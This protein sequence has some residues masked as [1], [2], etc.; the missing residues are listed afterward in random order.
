MRKT[1][2]L[3]G[4]FMLFCL[5]VSF[6]SAEEK[7]TVVEDGKPACAVVIGQQATNLEKHAAEEFVKYIFQM[8][9]P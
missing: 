7:L 5:S 6:V 1:F 4:A 2:I 9:L 3:F 8:I